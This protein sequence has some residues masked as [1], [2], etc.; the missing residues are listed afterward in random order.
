M[1][2]GPPGLLERKNNKSQVCFRPSFNVDTDVDNREKTRVRDKE[3]RRR[4]LLEKQP[5]NFIS[6]VSKREMLAARKEEAS[7]VK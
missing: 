5:E 6:A 2:R 7:K 1:A 4:I 3:Q